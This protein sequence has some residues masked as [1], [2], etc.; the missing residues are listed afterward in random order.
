MTGSTSPRRSRASTLAALETR[1]A[2]AARLAGAS[3][4]LH[5]QIGAPAWASVTAIHD[6][7]LEGARA[8]LGETYAAHFARGQEQSAEDAVAS[9][10]GEPAEILASGTLTAGPRAPARRPQ[11]VSGS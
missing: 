3:A 7:A 10:P 5:D 1:W 8:A 4:A 6:R 2:D 9:L 11:N